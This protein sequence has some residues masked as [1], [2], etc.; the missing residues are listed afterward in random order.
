MHP[1]KTQISLG[2]RRPPEEGLGPWPPIKHTSKTLNIPGR[3]QDWSQSLLD[4]R[5]FLLLCPSPV[6]ITYKDPGSA[7][8]CT[9][10]SPPPNS[11]QWDMSHFATISSTSPSQ[12][13]SEYFTWYIACIFVLLIKFYQFI[14]KCWNSTKISWEKSNTVCTQFKVQTRQLSLYLSFSEAW[15]NPFLPNGLFHLY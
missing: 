4:T 3:C 6:Q 1:A 10:T 8:A 13:S 11:K 9:K 2:I 12:F 15:L 14:V 5:S 7:I